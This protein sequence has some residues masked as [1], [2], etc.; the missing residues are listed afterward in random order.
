MG[1]IGLTMRPSMQA[2]PAAEQRCFRWSVAGKPIMVDLP[3]PTIETLSSEVRAACEIAGRGLE[4][5][6]L[7]L[8]RTRRKGRRPVVVIDDLEPVDCEHVA[9]PSY[10]LSTADRR[11][12]EA[13]LRRR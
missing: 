13:R 12:L 7:L 4:V 3:L 6:G 1:G 9:G 2:S 10:M 11:S 5:G 8:G